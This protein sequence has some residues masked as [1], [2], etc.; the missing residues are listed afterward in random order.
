MA[1]TSIPAYWKLKNDQLIAFQVERWRKGPDKSEAVEK[2]FP[3]ITISREFGCYGFS[4]AQDLAKNLNK[5]TETD[6][7]WA[8]FNRQLLKQI[9]QELRVNELLVESLDEKVENTISDF[10][11]SFGGPFQSYFYTKMFR[12]I[13]ALAHQ[14]QS[15]IVGRGAAII[16]RDVPHGLHIRTVAGK[17]WKILSIMKQKKCNEKDAKKFLSRMKR[18]REGYVN[19]YLG[20][21]LTDPCWYDLTFNCEKFSVEEII[22]IIL[23]T[24]EIRGIADRNN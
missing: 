2:K 10:F 14:G 6:I 19:K 17:E 12:T 20:K 13:L 4:L 15:I 18:E 1:Q 11:S 9:Q 8:A 5:L 7:P 16:T 22:S 23:N 21:N 24:L 3:F